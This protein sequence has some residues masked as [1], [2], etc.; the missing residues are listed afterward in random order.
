MKSSMIV[1]TAIA[2][3]ASCRPIPAQTVEATGAKVYGITGTMQADYAARKNVDAEGKPELTVKNKVTCDIVVADTLWFGGTI[4]Q[5]PGVYNS[6]GVPKQAG[7]VYYSMDLGLK[8]P[9]N[10]SAAPMVI[11]RFVGAVPVDNRGIYQYDRGN[12]RMAIDPKGQSAGFVSPFTGTAQGKAPEGAI[13]LKDK[14]AA[15]KGK[16]VTLKKQLGGK[17]VSIVVAKYDRMNWDA[18]LPAGP[19]KI[20]PECRVTGSQ[21]YDYERSAWYFDG[22]TMT[23]THPKTG[24][25]VTDR[26]S[27]NIKWVQSPNYKST[28][29]GTYQFDIRV[30]EPEGNTSGEAAVFAAADEE[31]FFATDA[32]IPS[33]QGTMKFK[34][35]LS[36][37]TVVASRVEIALTG[38]QLEKV[39]VVNLGKMILFGGV[40]P[41][42]DE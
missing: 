31:A 37:E 9:A 34:D 25:T 2:L 42:L 40:W 23:Y 11:G 15:M 12:L 21:L 36:Q 7:Q 17:Q 6:L 19:V 8:N 33:L 27:G 39:Q 22:V 24:K 38:N 26:L 29:E 35:T 32:G 28:G 14:W 16:A 18:G 30:N 10:L 5:L 1:L 3:I 13:S 41:L 20:Y 4:D